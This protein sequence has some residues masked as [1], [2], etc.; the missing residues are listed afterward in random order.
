MWHH[1]K[2]VLQLNNMEQID[3]FIINT[4][5]DKAALYLTSKCDK[6]ILPHY[7]L[8]YW[9]TNNAKHEFNGKIP[10][11]D[12]SSLTLSRNEN[13]KYD[14]HLIM[15]NIDLDF[16]NSSILDIGATI[17]I[18]LNLDNDEIKNVKPETS[19]LINSLVMG[20]KQKFDKNVYTV[21][22]NKSEIKHKCNLCH[23][24]LFSDDEFVGCYCFSREG[25][26]SC[27]KKGFVMV[28]FDKTLWEREEVTAILQ[29]LKK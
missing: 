21:K 3:K 11:V 20:H 25:T 4:V 15:D 5:G 12:D 28:E 18:C 13:G 26:K 22:F 19:K 10:G 9:L 27:N 2:E 29:I 24:R 6:S 8:L 7:L 1:H 23:N 14:G 16:I 17:A